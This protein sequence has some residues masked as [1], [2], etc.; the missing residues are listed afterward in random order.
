MPPPISNTTLPSAVPRGTS[1]RPTLLTLP[2]SEKLF[3]PL[4]S[5]LPLLENQ[6]APL[7]LGRTSRALFLTLKG[8]PDWTA[9]K[10]VRLAL[11]GCRNETEWQTV[12]GDAGKAPWQ[13][14]FVELL[15]ALL[16]AVADREDLQG[17][18]Q[19]LQEFV[20]E[21]IVARWPFP[22]VWNWDLEIWAP[23]GAPEGPRP[24]LCWS[25]A[26]EGIL[27]G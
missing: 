6:S 20:E 1:T 5:A 12:A 7:L 2:T 8:W 26:S 23:D 21:V 9:L 24:I 10:T 11:P 15:G 22:T 16:T 27:P 14:K 3:V 4:A 17:A 25:G 13:D 19:E 18:S